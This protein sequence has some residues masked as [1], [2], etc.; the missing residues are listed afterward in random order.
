MPTTA[1][2]ADVRRASLLLPRGSSGR[3]EPAGA[4]ALPPGASSR[5]QMRLAA[6]HASKEQ[7]GERHPN[8]SARC[9]ASSQ[10]EDP[11]PCMNR[12]VCQAPGPDQLPP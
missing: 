10:A 9:A 12:S 8:Y 5:P 1:I 3:A 4:L 2:D 6:P 11:R 7:R